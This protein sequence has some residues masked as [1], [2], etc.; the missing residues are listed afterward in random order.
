M[1]IVFFFLLMITI[2]PRLGQANTTRVT[3]YVFETQEKRKSTRWTLTEW[4]RIKERMKLMDVWLAMFSSPKK[5]VFAPELSLQYYSSKG[6]YTLN[7]NEGAEQSTE[8]DLSQ[9]ALLGQFWFTNLVSSTTGLSTLNID[10]GYEYYQQSRTADL[11]SLFT[12]SISLGQI[13]DRKLSH[14]VG[15]LRIFG[16]NIQDSSL[17]LKY[18]GYSLE[19]GIAPINEIAGGGDDITGAVAGAEATFY[20]LSWF[21]FEGSIMRYGNAR[22]AAG[23]E[24][25]NGSI[26]K[27]GAFIEIYNFRAGYG[28]SE[29]DWELRFDE[30]LVT[31]ES[32]E[33]EFWLVKLQF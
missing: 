11:S 27:Y 31:Q 22:G 19:P 29:E 6:D 10:L 26:T 30:G 20:L 18:G 24:E 5:E 25:R 15:L 14:H 23:S 28:V 7:L 16:K 4:L 9:E 3:T 13:S 33:G 32:N 8:T 1:R 12:G 2:Y 17:V 21:G